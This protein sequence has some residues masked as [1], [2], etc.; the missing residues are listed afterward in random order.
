MN[1]LSPEQI[2]SP[3]SIERLTTFKPNWSA[4]IFPRKEIFL[5][6]LNTNRIEGK[7]V[8]F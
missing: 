6:G 4:L 5:G 1:G 3:Y 8:G 7:Y 2:G